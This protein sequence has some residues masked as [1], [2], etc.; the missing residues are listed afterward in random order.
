M[1]LSSYTPIDGQDQDSD[2]H[3]FETCAG[4]DSEKQRL[5]CWYTEALAAHASFLEMNKAD[6]RIHYK[7]HD[8]AARFHAAER[9]YS[10]VIIYLLVWLVLLS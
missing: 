8:K 3:A 2:D 10:K 9:S 4:M 1:L 7:D 5:S 6:S